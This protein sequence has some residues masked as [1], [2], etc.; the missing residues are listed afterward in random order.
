ME[1]T[2]SFNSPYQQRFG[3]EA[4]ENHFEDFDPWS[5]RKRGK[6][7]QMSMLGHIYPWDTK[8]HIMWRMVKSKDP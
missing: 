1:A 7:P 5:T 2:E 4:Q 3:F 8:A 6:M